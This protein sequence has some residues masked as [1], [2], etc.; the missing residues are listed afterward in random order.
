MVRL[1]RIPAIIGKIMFINT[2]ERATYA[3]GPFSLNAY[4]R[5]A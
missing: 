1:A 3:G 4:L 2:R 5:A